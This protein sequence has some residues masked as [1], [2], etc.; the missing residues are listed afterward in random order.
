MPNI[1]LKL[2]ASLAKFSPENIAGEIKQIPLLENDTINSLV[3]RVN[4]G[5]KNL[6]LVILNGVYINKED[7]P[8]RR[9]SDGDVL[10]M[11]PP[12]VGG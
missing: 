7:R 12:I 3:D 9:L 1:T 6:H 10:A 2:F 11:W 5:D 4:L 8:T